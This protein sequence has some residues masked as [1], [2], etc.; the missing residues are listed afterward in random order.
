MWAPN[1]SCWTRNLAY[2]ARNLGWL[3]RNLVKWTRNPGLLDPKSWST[4]PE[5]S[6]PDFWSKTRAKSGTRTWTEKSRIWTEKCR[7]RTENF[8]RENPW[9]DQLLVLRGWC[10]M[11]PFLV[12]KA[13]I[14]WIFSCFFL[15]VNTMCGFSLFKTRFWPSYTRILLVGGLGRSFWYKSA[16]GHA[17]PCINP[18]KFCLAGSKIAWFLQSGFQKRET[19]Q[20][21]GVAPL[22]L[23]GLLSSNLNEFSL[24]LQTLVLRWPDPWCC[25]CRRPSS[26]G[27]WVVEERSGGLQAWPPVWDKRH[28]AA[29]A[30]EDAPGPYIEIFKCLYWKSCAAAHGCCCTCSFPT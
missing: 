20:L 16:L 29:A 13:P 15:Q 18:T 25:C 17:F 26:H 23:E 21:N 22:A 30:W 10:L 19:V 14:P 12:P 5:I 4:G 11:L 2:W 28:V 7:T 1:F 9:L 3:T 8:D 6:N 24:P 27:Q